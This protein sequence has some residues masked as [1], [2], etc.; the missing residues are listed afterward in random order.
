L[1]ETDITFIVKGMNLLR[2]KHVVVVYSEV[3]RKVDDGSL[4][5]NMDAVLEKRRMMVL[6][7]FKAY[8]QTD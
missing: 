8:F 1:G 4:G 7:V 6:E 2:E 3:M 5:Q